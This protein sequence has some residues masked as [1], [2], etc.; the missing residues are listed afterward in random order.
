MDWPA[1]VTLPFEFTTF[2]GTSI[3]SDYLSL[4]QS[5][6]PPDHSTAA[7]MPSDTCPSSD[8]HF[9]TLSKINV[10]LHALCNAIFRHAVGMGFETFASYAAGDFQGMD[11]FRVIMQSAQ[12]Y[13]ATIKA[14]H[15]VI[16]TRSCPAGTSSK[17]SLPVSPD[18]DHL[19]QQP[20][21]T[22][23]SPIA[24]LVVSCFVQLIR[25]LEVCVSIMHARIADTSSEPR[26]AQNMAFAGVTLL[27]FST[28]A[29]LAIELVQHVL[30]QIQL[31]LGLPSPRSSK[32][33]W[34][35]LLTPT[36]YREMLNAELGLVEDGWT[37]RPA[38]LN[39]MMS[40]TKEL[41]LERTMAG[42]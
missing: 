41:L 2:D 14:L 20:T 26:P 3:P 25:P 19:H 6:S 40:T 35:G 28:Q 15:R 27:D 30:S 36:K 37:V 13:L 12:E 39:E 1:R 8:V 17:Y 4:M 10:Q 24:Y 18:P 42:G 22:L 9:E 34:S 32:S 16:G 33:G 38:K 23:N 7:L 31:V 21:R 29:L 11:A 5:P